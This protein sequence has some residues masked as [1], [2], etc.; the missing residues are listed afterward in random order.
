MNLLGYI[1]FSLHTHTNTHTTFV[2]MA[3]FVDDDDIHTPYKA[4]SCNPSVKVQ[5]TL[6]HLK[7]LALDRILLSNYV[8]N[9]LSKF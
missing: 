3:R 6:S 4:P 7:L 2:P 8:H 1:I 9:K 5:H